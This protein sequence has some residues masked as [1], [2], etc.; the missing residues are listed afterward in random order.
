M[1]P[2]IA[3]SEDLRLSSRLQELVASNIPPSNTEIAEIR[4]IIDSNAKVIVQLDADI[5]SLVV[6]RNARVTVTRTIPFDMLAQ[7]FSTTVELTGDPWVLGQICRRWR[8]IALEFPDLWA[9]IDIDCAAANPRLRPTGYPL[10]KLQMLLDRSTG[11]PLDIC[12]FTVID[13]LHP[14]PV[15]Y[16]SD[17]LFAALVACSPRWRS[18]SLRCD[19]TILSLLA[20]IKGNVPM[21]Q[22]LTFHISYF[23]STFDG[24][25]IAPNLRSLDLSM[26]LDIPPEHALVL[27]WSQVTHFNGSFEIWQ[28]HVGVFNMLHN[29]IECRRLMINWAENEYQGTFSLPQLRRLYVMHGDCLEFT[30]PLLTEL[31][32]EPLWMAHPPD[33]FANLSQLIDHSSC[34]LTKLCLIAALTNDADNQKLISVLDLLPCLVDLCIQSRRQNESIMLD[35]VIAALVPTASSCLVPRL[36]TLTVGGYQITNPT[37]LVDML[38]TRWHAD[39][40]VCSTLCAF[41]LFHIRRLFVL[42]QNDRIRLG[43]FR[44]EAL[45]DV[46]GAAARAAMLAAPFSNASLSDGEYWAPEVTA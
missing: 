36:E 9:T 39:P 28:D 6:Q 33:V 10:R 5:E 12:F 32:V 8:E 27:P 4:A 40:A 22:S 37:A 29:I 16:H 24:F 34:Q 14:A 38:D 21:L 17:R 13:S 26:N 45:L 43:T 23:T 7:I 44:R 42:S 20:P 11:H 25:E 3:R 2:K 46:T 35:G 31:V 41:R 30:A 18:I 1:D 15:S 19:P